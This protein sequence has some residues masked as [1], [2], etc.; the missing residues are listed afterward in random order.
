MSVALG[1]ERGKVR[2]DVGVVPKRKV[3]SREPR[4][5][6]GSMAK[7]INVML[8]CIRLPM[9]SSPEMDEPITGSHLLSWLSFHFSK[10]WRCKSVLANKIRR[11]SGESRS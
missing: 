3:Q 7:G 9:T 6:N 4:W 5:P 11:T 8:L 2:G 1:R 10:T